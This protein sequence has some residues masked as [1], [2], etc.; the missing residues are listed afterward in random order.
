MYL[1]RLI[2][3][4]A[5]FRPFFVSCFRK[6]SVFW[7][8]LLVIYVLCHCCYC[9][10]FVVLL[11]LSILWGDRQSPAKKRKKS[12]LVIFLV[13][14]LGSH[15]RWPYNSSTY[16]LWYPVHVELHEPDLSLYCVPSGSC[17]MNMTRISHN[18][19]PYLLLKY[20]GTLCQFM[21]N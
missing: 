15:L 8:L 9:C 7:M 19:L 14:V 18:I 21:L 6:K 3:L 11:I 13:L 4:L 5:V 12:E 1:C 17:Q 2:L 10:C 20:D 16:T